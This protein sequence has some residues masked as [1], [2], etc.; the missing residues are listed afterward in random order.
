MP[1]LD[2]LQKWQFNDTLLARR[3]TQAQEWEE[4]FAE[5]TIRS[6]RPIL[7]ANERYIDVGGKTVSPLVI[8]FAFPDLTG[9]AAFISL[10]GTTGVLQRIGYNPRARV[11]L[12]ASC[13]ELASRTSNYTLLNCT[14]EAL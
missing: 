14:F 2:D 5:D 3:I 7:D 8:P 6:I 10:L 13:Q 12:F 9:R 11:A 1:F 4:W